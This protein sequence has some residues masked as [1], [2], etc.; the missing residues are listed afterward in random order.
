MLVGYKWPILNPQRRKHGRLHRGYKLKAVAGLTR[1]QDWRDVKA[2]S[3]DSVAFMGPL[4]CTYS[5][6][7]DEEAIA[8]RTIS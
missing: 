3:P 6:C 7:D 1:L 4:R 5:S 8:A 2:N